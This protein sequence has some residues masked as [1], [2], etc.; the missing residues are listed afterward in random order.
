LNDQEEKKESCP[1]LEHD[2][3]PL[4]GKKDLKKKCKP[5]FSITDKEEGKKKK[6]KRIG[7]QPPGRPASIGWLR[8]YCIR[9]GKRQFRGLTHKRGKLYRRNAH[10]AVE[11]PKNKKNFVGY[12]PLLGH[13]QRAG[14]GGIKLK[15]S[16]CR[17]WFKN[18]KKKKKQGSNA[19]R[20]KPQGGRRT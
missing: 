15:T 5:I 4:L 2:T 3:L 20:K 17:A 11:P 9:K 16:A 14:P 13:A 10:R 19:G 6:G 18:R 7:A 8:G 12:I 1:H